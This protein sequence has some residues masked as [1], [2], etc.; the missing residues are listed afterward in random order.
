MIEI[1]KNQL[2]VGLVS[3]DPSVVDFESG[4]SGSHCDRNRVL[5]DV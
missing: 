4:T 1:V 5:V 3:E 2:D